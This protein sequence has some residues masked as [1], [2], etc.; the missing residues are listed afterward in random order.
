M[1]L[2]GL[3][4]VVLILMVATMLSGLHLAAQTLGN[5]S[6]NI[7][8][9]VVA[10]NLGEELN[11]SHAAGFNFVPSNFQ[12]NSSVECIK[13]LISVCDNNNPSQFVCLNSA[14]YNQTYLPH[15]QNKANSN[16]V[17][18]CPDYLE[19]GEVACASQN[20]YCVVIHK[21]YYAPSNTTTIYQQGSGSQNSTTI[22]YG[23]SNTSTTTIGANVPYIG[24]STINDLIDDIDKVIQ[25]FEGLF[26]SL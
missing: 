8:S 16:G 24:S 17:V 18:A 9:T 12:S 5:A 1:E 10:V 21:P 22:T 25:F 2:K 26:K 23:S 11:N 15:E 13:A 19:A 7:N 4:F 6:N 14:A 20:G 3:A